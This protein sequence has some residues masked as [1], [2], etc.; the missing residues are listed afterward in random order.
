MLSRFL[1]LDS[2][3]NERFVENDQL[4]INFMI[5]KEG[6]NSVFSSSPYYPVSSATK[7]STTITKKVLDQAYGFGV[8]T[9]QKP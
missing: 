5:K 4:I 7:V 9:E 2:A 3:V 8:K 6:F 1:V